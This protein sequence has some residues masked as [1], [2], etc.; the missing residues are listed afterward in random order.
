M[1]INSIIYNFG[2]NYS[3]F[4]EFVQLF[5]C[6]FLVFCTLSIMLYNL[7]HPDRI[8]D[9]CLS[10]WQSHTWKKILQD[11]HQACEV[12]YFGNLEKTFLLVEIRT[13]K[14]G[15]LWA[16]VL[17]PNKTQLHEDFGMCIEALKWFLRSKW[18]VL[19]QVEWIEDTWVIAAWLWVDKKKNPIMLLL[20]WSGN[21]VYKEF[22][23][24]YNRVVDLTG[25]EDEIFAQ[26]KE[27]WRYHIHLAVKRWVTIEAVPATPENIDIWMKLLWDT[28]MRDRF[29]ANSR[30]YY[31]TFLHEIE[32]SYGTWLYFWRANGRV[33]V[34]W[35][36]VFTPDKAIYYYGASSSD[37]EDRKL[38][39]SYLLQWHAIREAKKRGI[40]YYDFLWVANPNNPNDHLKWVSDFKEK[41]WW[42]LVV[43]PSKLCITLSWKGRCILLLKTI[44]G[45]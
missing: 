15:M 6:F 9:S 36:F 45:K 3:M 42:Y 13:L 11:S 29:S 5:P 39:W 24:P 7:I 41:F 35:I 20:K 30:L 26:M 31:E 34:A 2:W 10:F 4:I 23:T 22:L 38:M 14:F 33:V 21:R 28:I 27:K 25:T 37:K 1:R 40:S 16:F 18:V 12:F 44:F 19:L 17:G 8:N 43:L 32:K